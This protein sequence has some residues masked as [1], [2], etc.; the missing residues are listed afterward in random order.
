MRR[1]PAPRSLLALGLSLGVH[2]CVFGWLIH[3]PTTAPPAPPPQQ[4]TP[5]EL[6]WLPT[7]APRPPSPAPPSP[8]PPAP[9]RKGTTGAP[10]QSPAVATPS[11]PAATTPTDPATTPRRLGTLLPRAD[12]LGELPTE[13]PRGRTLTPADLPSADQRR[14]QEQALVTARVDGWL[15]RHLARARVENHAYDPAY[16]HLGVAL[17]AATADVP[18]FIDTDSPKAVA[19]ALLESWGAGAARYARTGAPYAEPEGRLEQLERPSALADAIARGSPEALALGQ[20][21][22]AGARLQEF[23]DGRA[24]LELYALVELRQS[25]SGALEAVTLTRPSGLAPF[26]AWVL[27]R[28]RHVA[29]TARPGALR[30]LWRFDGVLTYRRKLKPG[31]L[32]GRAALGMMTMAALSLLSGLGNTMP[33]ETPGGPP[34][35][36]LGPRMPAV[37]GRFDELTGEVDVV[38]LTN[39]TYACR[40]TLLEAD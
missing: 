5:I 39:P 25:A 32:T 17:R 2:A 10:A 23:A 20:F 19:D 30:S 29:A 15:A 35:A 22:A 4:H 36:P 38:D 14:A 7:A 33:P 24:G 31:A 1:L 26:D 27:D 3:G 12:V 6:V 9:P 18:R 21:L 13:P 11:E 37:T 8:A 34:G 40:V 16:A 28:A